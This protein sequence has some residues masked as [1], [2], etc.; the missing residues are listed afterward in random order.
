MFTPDQI[1]ALCANAIQDNML[2]PSNR[3]GHFFIPENVLSPEDVPAFRE[4]AA[5]LAANPVSVGK[6]LVSARHPLDKETLLETE[7]YVWE[8]APVGFTS[9][10]RAQQTA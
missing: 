10:L 3:P 4:A 6:F 2:I 5:S 8:F 7:R 9:L 1:K